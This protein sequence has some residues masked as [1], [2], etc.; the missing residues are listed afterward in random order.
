M[1]SRMYALNGIL[2]MITFFI[3]R[4]SMVP[5]LYYQ[6][7]IYRN[8]PLFEVP[9]SIPLHCNV[10][11]ALFLSLQLYWFYLV[12]LSLLKYFSKLGT[13]TN[14]SPSNVNGTVNGKTRHTL[15]SKF[16]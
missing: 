16:Q 6:F 4:V 8:I 12:V 10:A 13:V 1:R 9:E 15:G 5:Y 3:G 7:S 14:S 11:S 2:F